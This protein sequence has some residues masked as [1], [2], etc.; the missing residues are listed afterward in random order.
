MRTARPPSDE[1]TS[2]Q[3]ACPCLRTLKPLANAIRRPSGD[4]VG[5]SSSARLRV[6]RVRL[7]PS[8]RI[9]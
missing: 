7:L 1:M 2:S 5:C 3:G 9:T 8:A 4:Q 6:S